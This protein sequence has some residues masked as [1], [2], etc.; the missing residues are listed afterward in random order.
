[1]ILN[2]WQFQRS[3]NSRGGRLWILIFNRLGA[4]LIFHI[5]G[6][7]CFLLWF[8]NR[9]GRQTA[10]SGFSFFLRRKTRCWCGLALGLFYLLVR[11]NAG[12]LVFWRG[13]S[14]LI[15]WRRCAINLWAL[16][17][18]YKGILILL[19]LCLTEL[20]VNS[21]FEILNGRF[22]EM[23][24][25]ICVKALILFDQVSE[26]QMLWWLRW[27]WP[28]LVQWSWRYLRRVQLSV[29]IFIIIYF[30]NRIIDLLN[31]I[32]ITIALESINLVRTYPLYILLVRRFRIVPRL[33][34]P[35]RALEPWLLP[36]TLEL[37]L[38]LSGG[39]FILI[40]KTQVL[41]IGPNEG[42]IKCAF[43][44]LFFSWCERLDQRFLRLRRRFREVKLVFAFLGRQRGHLMLLGEQS[45]DAIADRLLLLLVLEVHAT[46]GGRGEIRGTILMFWHYYYNRW[47]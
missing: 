47:G 3:D 43:V 27:L 2:L 35:H 34:P 14:S 28:W 22:I 1:M 4:A 46:H 13:G 8:I 23:I 30:N 40:D 9:R 44:F 29:Y 32:Q 11:I 42:S 25:H 45:G 38:M 21:L 17:T 39:A 16:H 10:P 41:A 15:I 36:R 26:I 6:C 5:Y 19:L 33:L 12:E 7:S 24:F 20:L 18:D 31:N 37:P